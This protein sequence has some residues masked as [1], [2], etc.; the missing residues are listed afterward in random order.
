MRLRI[1]LLVLVC[2]SFFTAVSQ[3]QPI[4]DNTVEGAPRA[5]VDKGLFGRVVDSKSGKGLDAAS[6]QVFAHTRDTTGKQRDS[7]IAGMLTKPNGDF[8]FVNLTL[9]D[10]FSVKVTALGFA[11][12]SKL[13]AMD[14]ADVAKLGMDVGNIKLANQADLLGSVTVVAQR[15]ALQMGIDRKIFNVDKNITSAGGTAVDVMKN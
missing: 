5:S 2:G 7:L 15:S 4:E 3:E 9:P 6:V 11:E 8:N 10:S 1:L 12:N 14:R 13:V